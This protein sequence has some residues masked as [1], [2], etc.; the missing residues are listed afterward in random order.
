MYSERNFHAARKLIYAFFLL[1]F[2]GIIC[3]FGRI[4]ISYLSDNFSTVKNNSAETCDNAEAQ[5]QLK[6]AGLDQLPGSKCK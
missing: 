4:V 3:A 5:A 1:F 2:I 6:K